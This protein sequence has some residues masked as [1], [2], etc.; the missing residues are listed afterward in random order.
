MAKP[1]GDAILTEV[2]IDTMRGKITEQKSELQESR[3]Q[4]QMQVNALTRK[5][6]LMQAELNRINALG[7]RVAEL[8]KIN[9]GEFDFSQQPGLGGPL[10][11]PA[12]EQNYNTDD[13]FRGLDDFD[14][15]ISDR[16]YQLEVLESVLLNKELSAEVR[17]SGRPITKGWTSSF[18]GTR[19]DPFT[20]EP[21]WHGGMDFA[22]KQGADVIATGS[23]VVTYAA[24]RYN[25]GLLVEINHGEGYVTRYAHNNELLVEVGDVVSKGEV[26]AKMGSEGR[27]TGPHVH[28]EII[29]HGKSLNP[30]KYV[31][32]R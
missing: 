5:I 24:K 30:Q 14:A 10:T 19:S 22:G 17:I 31:N 21:A 3:K 2:A 8:A 11:A 26:I 20:G 27:S 9:K 7:Q 13:L 12:T 23:G 32:R 1:S 29:R 16:S 18:Y 28:Y 4:A 6:G 25:Y 15:L